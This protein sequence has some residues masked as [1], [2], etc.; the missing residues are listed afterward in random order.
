MTMSI[1]MGLDTCCIVTLGLILFASFQAHSAYTDRQRY[2]IGMTVYTLI[3]VG[4]HIL[5]SASIKQGVATGAF[6][7]L[8]LNYALNPGVI[9]YWVSYSDT[10][11]REGTQF[12]TRA[13][14]ND[15]WILAL[16]LAMGINIAMVV[17]NIWTGCLFAYSPDGVYARGP[18]FVPRFLLLS[19]AVIVAETYL[20]FYRERIGKSAFP[21]LATI[22][23]APL[24]GAVLQAFAKGMLPLEIAGFT[25]S[26]AQAHLFIQDRMTSTDALTGLGNRRMLDVAFDSAYRKAEAGRSFSAL[27]LDIDKFKQINDTYGHSEGDRALAAVANVLTRSF[28]AQDVIARMSGDEFYVITDIDDRDTLAKA[29]GRLRRIFDEFNASGRLAFPIEVS[30]GFDVCDVHEYEGV[31][32]FRS[33]LDEMLYEEKAE[34]GA[35]RV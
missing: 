11:V 22:P 19:A 35:L 17:L 6:A 12:E 20:F 1:W 28:R 9:M 10:F 5:M 7:G 21:W 25:F 2:F 31:G 32:D 14:H 13:F 8:S 30:I 16:R 15:R 4:A 29:V 23:V 33:H 3:L 26:I 24:I 18:L 34:K 27:M